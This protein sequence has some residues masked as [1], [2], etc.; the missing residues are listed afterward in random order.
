MYPFPYKPILIHGINATA[1][2]GEHILDTPITEDEPAAVRRISAVL[3]ESHVPDHY[4][5]APS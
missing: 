3:L 2:S 4:D 5:T 1:K